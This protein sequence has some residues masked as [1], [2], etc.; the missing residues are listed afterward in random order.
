VALA[1]LLILS[2][3]AWGD[4]LTQS[5]YA[6]ADSVVSRFGRL[7]EVRANAVN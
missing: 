7:I 4:S 2:F 6:W 3:Y 1:L 5:L